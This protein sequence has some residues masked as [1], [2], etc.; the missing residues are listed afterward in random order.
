M[1]YGDRFYNILYGYRYYNSISYGDRIFNIVN[2]DRSSNILHGEKDYNFISTIVI[3]K[4]LPSSLIDIIN[5]K[6]FIGSKYKH[7]QNY[8][9]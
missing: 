3:H 9:N 7:L 2:R 6:N 4:G 5:I 8:C 1:V